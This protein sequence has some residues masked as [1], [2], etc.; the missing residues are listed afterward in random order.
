MSCAAGFALRAGRVRLTGFA[1]NG[2]RFVVN[3]LHIW[4]ARESSARLEGADLGGM[5]PAPEQAQLS[6]FVIPQRGVF[7]VGRAFFG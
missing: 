3:P 7:V 1:P 5:G 6:D 2:Q 4:V